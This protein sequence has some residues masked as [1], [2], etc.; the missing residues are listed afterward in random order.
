MAVY[1]IGDIQGCL[2]PFQRLLE[3]LQFDPT[4]DQLW[5][6]GDLVNRGPDSVG[7]LRLVRSLGAAAITVLGN[8]DLS[9]LAVAGKHI[10]AGRKDTYHSVLEAPDAAE[11]LD[12]LRHQPLV[13]HDAALGMTL[14][15]AG[16]A[17]QWD[18]ATA[19][20]CSA[21][22]QHVLSGAQYQEF[23]AVM[24]GKE[25]RR[26]KNSLTGAERWRAI[27]NV[28]TRMRYC[29]SDG[30]LDFKDKGPLGS[31]AK[32]LIP[33]FELPERRNRDLTIIFGHW[34]A[35]GYYRAPGIIALDTGCVWGQSLTALRLDQAH[36]QPISVP[37]HV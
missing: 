20:Q 30:T 19:L 15:H 10:E 37:A 34:A 21:E 23:L 11:L 35:L 12:W 32:G 33:W 7:V 17:P 28:C 13:H 9:L 1:A 27:V 31:Q 14:V 26:W 8:H 4:H 6:T 36:A 25:P 16:L 29:Q 18:L 3:Q 5:L 2:E 24:F 22:L